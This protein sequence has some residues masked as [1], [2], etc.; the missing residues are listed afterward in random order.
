LE[1]ESTKG[2]NGKVRSSGLTLVA[3]RSGVSCYYKTDHTDIGKFTG[4]SPAT[5]HLEAALPFHWGS[6][7]CGEGPTLLTGSYAVRGPTALF[8]DSGPVEEVPGTNLTSPE[9]TVATPTINAKAEGHVVLDNPI[10]TIQCAVNLEGTVASHGE[11]KSASGV[12]SALGFTGCTNSWHVTVG[13]PGSLDIHWTSGANGTVVS[14]G[15]TIEATRFG[16]TCR[17]HTEVTDLGTLTGGSPA[18][19]DL[20]GSVFFHS[21]SFLCGEGAT[22]WTGAYEISAPS[23]LYVDNS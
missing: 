23:S 12:L 10:A 9:G 3:T 4:G 22:T 11:G 16:V 2:Y 14:S 7:L 6:E 13:S 17:Y 1:L 18:T 20:A 15:A 21:G 5:I 19:L 8:A